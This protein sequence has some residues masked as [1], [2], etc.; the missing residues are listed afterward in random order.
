M[1][2]AEAFTLP[3]GMEGKSFPPLRSPQLQQ[4]THTK[5]ALKVEQHLI[6][7]ISQITSENIQISGLKSHII[8]GKS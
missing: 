2:S 6:V 1:I 7:P 3:A 5:L 4:S 8:L